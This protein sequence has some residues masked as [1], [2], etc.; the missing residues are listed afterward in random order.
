[1]RDYQL[2]E[3][4]K[5]VYEF[6]WT[7]FADW[8][9][10]AAKIELR[11][12]RDDA[13]RLATE[14][15][16]AMVLEKLLRLLHP[17]APFVTEELWQRLTQAEGSGTETSIMVAPWPEATPALRDA[18]IERE[19][20]DLTD[21]AV[22]VRRLRSDY[23]LEARPLSAT[24]VAGER[25]GHW[26][27]VGHLLAGL[28]R[29]RLDPLVVV[30][31]SSGAPARSLVIVAGG[32]QALIPVEG[33]VD[34]GREIQRLRAEAERSRSEVQRLSD[35]LNRPGFVAQ[36][37]PDVVAQNRQK[38]ADAEDRF[39]KLEARRAELE[40]LNDGE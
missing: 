31:E 15:T 40:S 22:E 1:M 16:L 4:A 36:A 6:I 28:P 27:R 32:V 18:A 14:R 26:S 35:L 19:W 11:Q 8:Y 13:G 9:V 23:Q 21:L 12:A 3:A 29:V 24:L 34:L 10:E 33:V 38:L 17:F 5:T 20:Q 2:G 37:P 7:E 39:A 30:S 25:S